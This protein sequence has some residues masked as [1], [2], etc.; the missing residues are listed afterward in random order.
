MKYVILIIS[1]FFFQC[2][3]LFQN[4]KNFDDKLGFKMIVYYEDREE[5]YFLPSEVDRM[6][7]NDLFSEFSLRNDPSMRFIT[8]NQS[9][10]IF[11]I[12]GTRNNFQKEW[13]IYLNGKYISGSVLKKGVLVHQNSKLVLRYTKASR[14]ILPKRKSEE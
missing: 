12:M 13:V 7:L 10:D 2:G 5:I 3:I 8:T 14:M 11:D 4:T 9:I 1:I 6:D